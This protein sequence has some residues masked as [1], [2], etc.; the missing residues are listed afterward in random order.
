M[1]LWIGS[2]SD[3]L[4]KMDLSLAGYPKPGSPGK[5]ATSQAWLTF[6]YCLPRLMRLTLGRLVPATFQD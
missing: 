3:P 1:P 6:A 5:P 4:I 2:S